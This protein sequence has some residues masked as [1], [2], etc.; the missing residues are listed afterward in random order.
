MKLV[1]RLTVMITEL[2]KMDDVAG[3]GVLTLAQQQF[4]WVATLLAQASY[5][6]TTGRKLHTALAELGQFCGWGTYEAGQR[7][8]AQRCNIAALRAASSADDR[9]W[10][11]TS[12][13]RCPSRPLTRADPPKP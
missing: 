11:R 8:L 5:E 12:S 2:R 3:G 13:D 10:A 9:P 6:D 7:G 1:D 4:D